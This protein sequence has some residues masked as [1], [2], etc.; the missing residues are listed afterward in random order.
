[1]ARSQST[2]SQPQ[3]EPALQRLPPQPS[4][5]GCTTQ[6]LS[7]RLQALHALLRDYDQDQ[8][9]P[10]SLDD[11]AA[12]LIHPSLLLHKDRGIKAYTACC[13]VDI[14]RLYAPDAPYTPAQLQ[15]LFDFLIR[16]FRFVGSPNDPHQAEY[17][18]V[19][20]SLASVKSIVIICDL[21]AGD[22][23]VERVFKESFDTIS[24]NSPKNVELALSDILISL[25]EE[26][27]SVPTPVVDTLTSQFLPKAIKARPSAFRLAQEVCKTSA[28]KL[29]R[30]VS[31][32]FGEIIV[33]QLEGK[34]SYGGSDHE[35][36]TAS[37]VDSDEGGKKKKGRAAA[38]AA[39]KKLKGKGKAVANGDDGELPAAFVQAHELIRSL[40]RHVPAL[41][42]SVIPQLE[43]ELV[44]TASA[45]YRRLA[46]AVLGAMFAEPPGHGDLAMS[47]P[48]TW[49]EWTRRSLDKE[50]KVRMQVAEKVGK[51][52]R[53]HPELSVDIENILTRL[54]TDTDERVRIAAC[55]VF[56]DE[57]KE[58][59]ADGNAGGRG[60]GMDYETA[61]H[62][63][64]LKMLQT[65]GGRVIDKKD[66]VRALAAKAL[67]RLYDLAYPEIESRDD[68]A[69]HQFGWIPKALLSSLSSGVDPAAFSQLNLIDSIFSLYVL[70]RPSTEKDAADADTVSAW[71]DR[72]LVV[73]RR[74]EDP[75]QKGALMSLTKLAERGKHAAGSSV[76]DG[77][78]DV[79]VK[80]NSG[81]VDDEDKKPIL[82]EFLNRAIQAIA[83]RMPE[84]SKANEDLHTF[85]KQNV[86]QMYRELKVLFDAQTD[87]KTA[88]KNERDFL[89][90]LEKFP[91][92]SSALQTFTAFL[93][94]ATYP[95]LSRSSI[96]QLLKRLQGGSISPSHA[97]PYLLRPTSAESEADQLAASAARVLD[98]VS[99]TKPALY[100]AH[101]AELTKVL[102]DEKMEAEER[103]KS[104]EVVLRAV[105]CLKKTDK[106]VVVDA[107]LSKRC[108]HFAKHGSERQAKQAATV[109][110]LDEGRAGT[111]DDLVDHLSSSLSSATDR[112][113][114]SHFAALAR[115]ARYARE[116]FETKSEDITKAALEVLARAGGSEETPDDEDLTYFDDADLPALTRARILSIKVLS[117]RCLA[118]AGTE[119]AAKAAKP[120][121][122]MLWTHLAVQGGGD[123]ETYS[124]PVASRLRLAA[125]LALLKLLASKDPTFTKL[126]LLHLDQLSR[127]AQDACFE[128]RDQFLK[129]LMQYLRERRFLPA[130]VPRVNMILFLVAH[131]PEAEL[132]DVVA[133]FAAMRKRLDGKD[134]QKNW[135]AP[136]VRLVHMLAHHPDFEGAGANGE[137]DVEELKSIAKYLEL[138]FEIFVTNENVA[139]FYSLAQRLKTV[140][141]KE[142]DSTN[143]YILSELAQY[144]LKHVAG[145]HQWPINPHPGRDPLPADLFKAFKTPDAAKEIAKRTYIEE[146]VLAKLDLKPEKKK[147]VTRKR[148]SAAGA[149]GEKKP[150]RPRV[151]KSTPSKSRAKKPAKKKG[152]EW[153]SDEQDEESEES[154]AS[155]D[156]HDDADSG[157]D[158]DGEPK[159]KPK[160]AA[161][162]STP[163][164][165]RGNLRSDPK[166]QVVKGLGASGSEDE[167]DEDDDDVAMDV[168]EAADL[169]SSSS[170]DAAAAKKPKANGK[171]PAKSPKK[172]A[173]STPKKGTAA[174][175]KKAVAASP[176][177][178][179]KKAKAAATKKD[180]E[181]GG[182]RARPAKRGLKQPRALKQGNLEPVSDIDKSDEEDEEMGSDD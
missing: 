55:G 151:S 46:T 109:I 122:D 61:A 12:E 34:G 9:D 178:K 68:H 81:I 169:S 36:D 13:L 78:V 119:S 63:V 1:M 125:A 39:K 22:E 176:A 105:A 156:E 164:G 140:Q 44:S 58:K 3:Q 5:R 26:L 84:Q 152:E 25:L 41:L 101:M 141:D 28:D 27:P 182:P 166:K 85:A 102:N 126:L 177:A 148:P 106:E 64:S 133:T 120:V 43:A 143:L 165:Q 70:P 35:S 40:H 29:Q 145:R 110:A 129:K 14:L 154:D 113:L 30:H 94:L 50:S 136:F 73:E 127:L 11:V 142:G 100:K 175:G 168:D 171:A 33:G 180:D 4:L 162:K 147:V 59:D 80:Y 69:I 153:D 96:P 118:F 91:S 99:R 95:Y 138:Y 18:Y 32:Y 90:R 149:N 89:R 20:D 7:K 117:A 115:I 132:K 17:F 52:W 158:D 144:L 155:S 159:A 174:K 107:K 92:P 79:C 57:K 172:A 72:F 128:V 121:F 16:Q 173:A 160:K 124:V 114:V 6:E 2:R 38:A 103:E 98:Y 139:Y 42:V 88:V 163:R 112:E 65:L 8:V 47:F 131:E 82:K 108:L 74:I 71:V 150:K 37:E 77:F 93:R 76:W 15:D 111:A 23:L 170:A 21:D 51:I 161:S 135:E 31:Q 116:A 67:G 60:G 24:S 97:L 49:K 83:Q 48:G 181:D 10:S 146:S 87:L 75:K 19:V 54:L 104:A 123:G 167:K 179:G 137:P 53:E 157:S 134:R 62:H 86:Q 56:Y 45:A 130:V 66:K